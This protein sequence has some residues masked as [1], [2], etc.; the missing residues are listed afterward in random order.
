M[1]HETVQDM[2]RRKVLVEN[3][4][5]QAPPDVLKADGSIILTLG[6]RKKVIT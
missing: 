6:L 3:L 1:R 5:G 4:H 2:N